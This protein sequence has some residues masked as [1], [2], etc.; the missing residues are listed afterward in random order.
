[1]TP[2][3]TRPT[4]DDLTA[5]VTGAAGGIGR[6]IAQRLAEDGFRL[7]LVDKDAEGLSHVLQDLEPDRHVA[8]TL[9]LADR[10]AIGRLAQAAPGP[11]AILVNNAALAP[12]H[13]GRGR[14]VTETTL[15][16]WDVVLE[17]NL[18]S[19]MWLC[20]M[21]LPAMQELG[22]GRVINISSTAGRSAGVI[23]GV[24]YMATK[25]ALIGLTRHVAGEYGRHG[26]TAN[27]I[28]PGRIVTPLTATWS[29]EQDAADEART[30]LARS[31][32]PEEVA[33][34]VAY[35]ASPA[36]GFTTGAV[37]DVNGGIFM[38]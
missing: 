21:F 15:E 31:G 36:A 11:V 34:A 38:G 5:L 6:A 13:G 22:W 28:A 33:E 26:I 14:S 23:N 18:T 16:E 2:P 29:A 3:A 17:V 27:A 30:P 12:K 32:R 25:A 9:D 7:L 19:A 10:A 37:L 4:R 35:L 24:S 8:L 20:R 1:M